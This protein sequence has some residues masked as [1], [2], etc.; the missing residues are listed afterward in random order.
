MIEI[1]Y[2]ENGEPNFFDSFD[3]INEIENYENIKYIK[4]SSL[5]LNKIPNNLPK[6]LLYL[7]CS[8]NNL[9]EL[10]SLPFKLKYLD[11]SHNK[12]TKLPTLPEQLKTL[13]C[14]DN[15]FKDNTYTYLFRDVTQYLYSI[16]FRIYNSEIFNL[17][18]LT[19]NTN[20]SND[21]FTHDNYKYIE[22]K[23]LWHDE[24]HQKKMLVKK[25]SQGLILSEQNSN[26]DLKMKISYD[27][28]NLF[29]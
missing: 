12:L 25:K 29:M 5:R 27:F 23:K 6:D 18:H 26:F 14:H 17:S 2:D 21:K 4:C 8:Y 22:R 15:M 13:I 1:K 9:C 10:P 19:N 11:C 3:K 20:K 24:F 16:I 7:D 28:N